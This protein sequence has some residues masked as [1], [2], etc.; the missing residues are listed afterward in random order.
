MCIRAGLALGLAAACAGASA[1]GAEEKAAWGKPAGGVALGLSLSTQ[2]VGYGED[3]TLT[4]HARNAGETP[5]RL[6]ALDTAASTEFGHYH[7][8]IVQYRRVDEEAWRYCRFHPPIGQGDKMDTLLPGETRAAPFRS[9][10]QRSTILGEYGGPASLGTWPPMPGRYVVRARLGANGGLRKAKEAGLWVDHAVSGDVQLTMLPFEFLGKLPESPAVSQKEIAELYAG[11]FGKPGV[12]RAT[13]ELIKVGDRRACAALLAL[14]RDGAC[15]PSGVEFLA[16]NLGDAITYDLVRASQNSLSGH[17]GA[18]GRAL[19]RLGTPKVIAA[20]AKLLKDP[21][22]SARNPFLLGLGES[23]TPESLAL[24]GT[25]AKGGVAEAVAPLGQRP[26]RDARPLLLEAMAKAP[27]LTASLAARILA[28]RGE[29]AAVT[30]LSN[31][32]DWENAAA[33]VAAPIRWA[34]PPKGMLAQDKAVAIAQQ[35]LRELE[36]PQARYLDGKWY[37]VSVAGHPQ[38]RGH[39]AYVILDATDGRI[40]RRNAARVL[41]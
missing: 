33:F 27:E 8:Y 24:L 22:W 9:D 13:A 3:F 15:E 17:V 39:F 37:V 7:E 4:L 18:A 19:G 28:G 16:S 26:A 40:L 10:E 35:A 34:A 5:I 36:K 25:L 38:V 11:A 6:I 1:A 14:V 21:N 31:H 2:S 23:A 32:W 20:V 29:E 12:A 30:W 41:R